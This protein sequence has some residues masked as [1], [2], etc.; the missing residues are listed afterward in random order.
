M[1]RA[2]LCLLLTVGCASSTGVWREVSSP[3]FVVRTDLDAD[4]ARRA[5]ATLELNRSML[6]SAAWP[7]TDIP[8]WARTEVYVLDGAEHQRWFGEKIESVSIGGVPEQFYFYGDPGRWESRSDLAVSPVST[9]RFQLAVRMSRILYPDCPRWFSQGIARFLET[10]HLSADGGSVVMGAVNISELRNYA[11]HRTV[12]LADLLAWAEGDDSTRWGL[13]GMS[14][15][16]VHWLANTQSE[17]FSRY[18]LALM[19]GAGAQAAFAAAF[20]GLDLQATDQELFRYSKHGEYGEISAPLLPTPGAGAERLLTPS[21]LH[22]VRA[23]LTA[24]AWMMNPG[25]VS[26]ESMNA[27]VREQ[28]DMS[29]ALDSTNVTAQWLDTWS[30]VAQRLSRAQAACQ[31][32]PEDSRAWQLLGGLLNDTEAKFAE[33]ENAY[34]RSLALAP[35]NPDVLNDLAWMLQG[36]GRWSAAMPLAMKAI[37]V[38]PNSPAVLDTY[39]AVMLKAG[40]CTNALA[41]QQR[42]LDR[43]SPASRKENPGYE[44]H[45]E[46]YRAACAQRRP[47]R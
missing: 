24:A 15:L 38:A 37:K 34:R 41:A 16:F 9:L 28:V 14:W 6:V 22:V 29:L 8:E 30:P 10:V 5:A 47:R 1:S 35:N 42:A 32:H 23:R 26:R 36:Q 43:L 31:A 20:P 25:S 4:V 40:S 39:A 18:R 44:Q 13:D 2:I 12:T 46:E 17:R 19:R 33:V 3:H 7:K 21:D 27:K 11:Q 45:L